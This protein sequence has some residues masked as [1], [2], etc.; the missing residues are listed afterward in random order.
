MLVV[1]WASSRSRDEQQPGATERSERKPSARQH[2]SADGGASSRGGRS[3]RAAGND[4]G[5][6]GASSAARPTGW[7]LV[8]MSGVPPARRSNHSMMMHGEGR[9][10]IFGGFDGQSFLGDCV[11]AVLDR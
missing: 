8:E 10:L 6:G 1:V 3:S 7:S 5:A 11:T 2:A 4:A 9:V